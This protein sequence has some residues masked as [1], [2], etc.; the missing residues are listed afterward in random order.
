MDRNKMF[1]L[2]IDLV[3]ASLGCTGQK[4]KVIINFFK[5]SKYGRLMLVCH[6]TLVASYY[7]V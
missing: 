4:S 1:Q 3:R 2:V 5:K 6:F 7:F